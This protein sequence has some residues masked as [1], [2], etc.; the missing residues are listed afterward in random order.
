MTG[1]FSAMLRL[2][3]LGVTEAMPAFFALPGK[4]NPL[5]K[6]GDYLTLGT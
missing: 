3:S 2:K 6:N 1:A 5:L 4:K